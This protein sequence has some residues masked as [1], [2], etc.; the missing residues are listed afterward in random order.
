MKWA[1]YPISEFKLK[2][3]PAELCIGKILLHFKFSVIKVRK[4]FI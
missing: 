2:S 4:L 3:E 1:I